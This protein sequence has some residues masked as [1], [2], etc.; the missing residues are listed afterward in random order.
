MILDS[1]NLKT[2]A[3]EYSLSNFPKSKIKELIKYHKK[4]GGISRYEKFNYF[5]S[6]I[7]KLSDYDSLYEES[8]GKFSY[9]VEKGID[10]CSMVSGVRKFIRFLQKNEKPIYVVSGS[11]QEELHKIFNKRGIDKYFKKIYGSPK[12][13]ELS[14]KYIKQNNS[15]RRGIFFGDSLI[16][17]ESSLISGLKFIYVEKHSEWVPNKKHI[18]KTLLKI[19]DFEDFFE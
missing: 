13:K 16:D 2:D 18:K 7:M 6:D 5:F 3:F 9:F 19:S 14:L 11:D 8:L 12:S 15:F 10:N 1:N 17:F 4:N